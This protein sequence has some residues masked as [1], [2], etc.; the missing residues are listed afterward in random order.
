CSPRPP[1]DA[2]SAAAAAGAPTAATTSPARPPPAAPSAAPVGPEP[3]AAYPP[4][5][6]GISAAAQ[7]ALTTAPDHSVSQRPA[8]RQ[9]PEMATR[10]QPPVRCHRKPIRRHTCV[11]APPLSPRPHSEEPPSPQRRWSTR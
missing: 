8:A 5:L 11:D 3:S 6:T 9:L 2:P 1:P 4:L 7:R 10:S